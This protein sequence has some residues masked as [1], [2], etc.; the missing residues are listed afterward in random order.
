ML[1]VAL[2]LAS[3]IYALISPTPIGRV[4]W[5]WWSYSEERV[6]LG[7]YVFGGG[8]DGEVISIS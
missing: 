1:R 3:I 4:P 2:R 8:Y 5:M 7:S 6:V